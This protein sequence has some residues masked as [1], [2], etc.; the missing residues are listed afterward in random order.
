MAKNTHH[1]GHV[2]IDGAIA[3]EKIFQ[4]YRKHNMCVCCGRWGY[5]SGKF[6]AVLCDGHYFE[7]H[8]QMTSEPG[9]DPL[10]K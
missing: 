9:I 8:A 7:K 3:G 6:R 1:I 10:A 5:W 4:R 2:V